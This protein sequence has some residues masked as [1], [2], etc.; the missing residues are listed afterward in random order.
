MAIINFSVQGFV[1]NKFAG[2][3]FDVCSELRLSRLVYEVE[4]VCDGIYVVSVVVKHVCTVTVFLADIQYFAPVQ[5]AAC[6]VRF[7][8]RFF[9]IGVRL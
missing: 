4:I 8:Y 5:N 1:Q 3:V 2:F 6:F 7:K 9:G